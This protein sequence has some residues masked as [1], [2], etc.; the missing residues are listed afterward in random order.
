MARYRLS[1]AAQ[2][3]IVAILAWTHEQFGEAA[4]SRYEALIVARLR[5][6]AIEPHRAGS[7]DRPELGKAFALGTC[8][9]V[10]SE[11]ARKQAWCAGPGIS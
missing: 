9:S 5:D 4:R 1:A 8:V 3:D 7:I 10:D 11:H 2:A 6:I